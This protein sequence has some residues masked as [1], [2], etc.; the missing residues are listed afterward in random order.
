[1]RLAVR[2]F[3][4]ISAGMFLW[5]QLLTCLCALTLSGAAYLRVDPKTL[6]DEMSANEEVLVNPSASK[7]HAYHALRTRGSSMLSYNSVFAFTIMAS[8]FP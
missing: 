8:Q 7:A 4:K 3:I 1:M 2:A 6:A 5:Q